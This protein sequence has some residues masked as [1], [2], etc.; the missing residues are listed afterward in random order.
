MAQRALGALGLARKAG[1]AVS[2]AAKVEASIRSGE[3]S[4]AL[5]AVDGADDGLRKMRQAARATVHLG[6][7][8][9]PVYRLFDAE[10][11]GLALG[12]GSVI[13]AAVLG[14]SAG[15]AAFERI[16]AL[17]LYRQGPEEHDRTADEAALKET[18]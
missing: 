7:P 17:A 3:A 15:Q 6:G 8:E 9:I 11:L 1:R 13:H 18:E 2:G 4:C 14:R 5:H 16:A 12:T 10:Q